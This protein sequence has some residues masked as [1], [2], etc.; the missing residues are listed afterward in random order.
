MYVFTCL[1]YCFKFMKRFIYLCI[2]LSQQNNFISK[3]CCYC[4]AVTLIAV[5]FSFGASKDLKIICEVLQ[6]SKF[7]LPCI[8]PILGSSEKKGG[9]P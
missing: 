7:S 3:V 9:L 5:M 4:Y 2:F 1:H 6:F 8:Y